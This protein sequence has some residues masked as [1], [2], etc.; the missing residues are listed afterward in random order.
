MRQL[1]GRALACVCPFWMQCAGAEGAMSTQRLRRP[2][3]QEGWAHSPPGHLFPGTSRP[4]RDTPKTQLCLCKAG[5]GSW[6]PA[7]GHLCGLG[8]VCVSLFSREEG[9]QITPSDSCPLTSDGGRRL[10]PLSLLNGFAVPGHRECAKLPRA[11]LR[12]QHSSRSTP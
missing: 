2:R 8:H 3:G 12:P 7:S 4:H 11:L 5:A 1:R 6:H 10:W 9:G